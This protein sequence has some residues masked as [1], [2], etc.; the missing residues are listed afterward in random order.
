M[1]VVGDVR[2]D[3]GSARALDRGVP[4]I[5]QRTPDG[6]PRGYDG[7]ANCGPSSMAMIARHLGLRGGRDA[8]LVLE[9]ARI[10]GTNSDV[11]TSLPGMERI[12]TRLGLTC[13][14]AQGVDLARV[15]RV[16]A[17]GG[18]VVANGDYYAMPPHEDPTQ[19][20]GH[21]VLVYGID[22]RGRFLVHDPYDH[23]VESV[24]AP[25]LGR[26]LAAHEEGGYT[27]AIDIAA[28]A[29][30]MDRYARLTASEPNRAWRAPVAIPGVGRSAARR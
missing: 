12:A 23:A 21:Y 8:A 30:D 2:I 15:R 10:G 3:A 1:R 20:E 6:A 7:E 13:D 27:L 28:P 18:Y 14:V 5:S 16:L 4:Y 19:Y 9:L 17:A 29:I 22:P 11:G 25:E 26:F 24:T